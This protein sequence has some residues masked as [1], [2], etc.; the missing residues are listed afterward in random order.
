M[1][2]WIF[3]LG[4]SA[5]VLAVASVMYVGVVRPALKP[6]LR[7]DPAPKAWQ[8][9]QVVVEP[10]APPSAQGANAVVDAAKANSASEDGTEPE[11]GELLEEFRMKL[12]QTVKQKKPAIT[13]EMLDT[14]NSYQD[15]AALVRMLASEDSSRVATVIKQMIEGSSDKNR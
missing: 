8:A 1:H 7:S 15:K 11:T 3:F 12:R 13:A 6:Q 2:D 14:A 5:L 10:P 4:G 9:D